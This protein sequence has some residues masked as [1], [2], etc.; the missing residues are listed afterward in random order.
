MVPAKELKLELKLTKAAIPLIDNG[1]VPDKEL[2]EISKVLKL[3]KALIV[4]GNGPFKALL[5]KSTVVKAVKADNELICAGRV[6]VNP[7][8]FRAS[9][10]TL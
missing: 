6:P 9:A 4:D 5:C 1:I 7:C 3:V 8:P 10:V 2:C